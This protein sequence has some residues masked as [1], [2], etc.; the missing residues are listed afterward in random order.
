MKVRILSLITPAPTGFLDGT[1][2]K[3]ELLS[4]AVVLF[5]PSCEFAYGLLENFRTRV[6]GILLIIG[7]PAITQLGPLLWHLSLPQ[8]QINRDDGPGA[9]HSGDGQ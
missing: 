2:G 4:G 1:L 7:D 8:A 3:R 9:G 6:E 5:T